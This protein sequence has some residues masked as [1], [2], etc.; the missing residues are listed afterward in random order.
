MEENKIKK[1]ENE[2]LTET[3]FQ[4]NVETVVQEEQPVFL[5]L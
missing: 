2:V 5:C 1:K 4:E 3:P